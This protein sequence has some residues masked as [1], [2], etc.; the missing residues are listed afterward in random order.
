MGLFSKRPSAAPV[1]PSA[2][3]CRFGNGQRVGANVIRFSCTEPG[4]S[5]VE[6]HVED[7]PYVTKR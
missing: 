7:D 1:E 5:V 4:C 2:H 3:T 6:D